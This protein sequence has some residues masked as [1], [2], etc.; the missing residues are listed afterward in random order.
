MLAL[1]EIFHDA[2]NKTYEDLMRNEDI[3]NEQLMDLI[4]TLDRVYLESH[5]DTFIRKAQFLFMNLRDIEKTYKDIIQEASKKFFNKNIGNPS[6]PAQLQ[7]ILLSADVLSNALDIS[8]RAQRDTIDDRED[9]MMNNIGQWHKQFIETMR[10]EEIERHR[11][12][13]NEICHLI[14]INREELDDVVNDVTLVD[15][16][17]LT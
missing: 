2:C 12:C 10:E 17:L 16:E 3:L 9:T 8:D 14:D 11:T 15:P 6:I 1:N 7:Q 5:V 13:V 4:S